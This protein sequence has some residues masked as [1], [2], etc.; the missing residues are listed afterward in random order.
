MSICSTLPVW[1]TRPQGGSSRVPQ[2]DVTLS[3]VYTAIFLSAT[4]CLFTLLANLKPYLSSVASDYSCPCFL[5]VL[6]LRNEI[7][8]KL[9]NISKP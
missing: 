4:H 9:A 8:L 2:P 3:V 6:F 7:D 1:H 5:L